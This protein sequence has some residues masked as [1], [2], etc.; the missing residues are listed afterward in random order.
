MDWLE[1][2]YLGLFLATFL[3]ATVL[4]FSSE[5]ILGGMLY[6]GFDPITCLV[7]ATV[8]NSLGGFSSYGLG[9]LGDWQKLTKWLRTDEAKV[10]KWQAL[11]KRYGS[12]TAILCWLP[13]VG[14]VIAIAL[15]LFKTPFLPVSLWM[16]LGK[17]LRYAFLTWL[18]LQI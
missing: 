10:H 14:D 3:A 18:F 11:I 7:V 5:A 16:V 4:P 2:G 17:A 9:Y 15:G 13:I 12:F 1:L 8:G 6:A